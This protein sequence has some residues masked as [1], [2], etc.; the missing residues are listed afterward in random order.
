MPLHAAEVVAALFAAYVLAG[1]LFAVV[2][3]SRGAVRVDPHLSGSSI[4]V[5]LLILP[6]VAALWPLMAR[7]WSGGA[8][9]PIERNAHRDAAMRRHPH[10]ASR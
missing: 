2:F 1:L 7:R 4:L 8:E 6:G 5:R 9:A 10:E 3:V